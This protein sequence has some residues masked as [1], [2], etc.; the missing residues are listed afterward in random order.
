M[1]KPKFDAAALPGATATA[2][3]DRLQVAT[4]LR[5]LFNKIFPDHWSFLLG[6]IALYSFIMLLL[7]GTFIALFFDPSMQE[8][9][10]NGSYV[11][12]QGITMSRAYETT[13]NLSFDVRGGLL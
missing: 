1:N 7:T 12:L 6:E 4:P 9:K 2:I 8:V 5:R 13:L 11:P 10:Y 3:D